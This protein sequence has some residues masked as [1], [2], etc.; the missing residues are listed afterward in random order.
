MKT[1]DPNHICPYTGLRSFTEEESLYFKGRDLQVDQITALLEQNKFLMVTGASGEG[2]SSLI[3]A[4]LI[5]NARAGFF[6]ARYSNWLV[7]DFR[8]ER[9][10]VANLAASIAAQLQLS[11]AIVET[12]L[13]RGYSSLVDLYLNSAFYAGEEEISLE[14]KRQSANLLILVDQFEE[15]FTNPENFFND[16][17][18]KDAQIV[19]NLLLETARISISRNLPVYV[20][21][22]MRSDYIGQCSSFRGLPEYIGF[23]QFF[24]PRLKR[25]DLKQVIEEPA[26]LSGNRITQRLIE[27]LVYDLADGVDQL[28]I[29][30]HALSRIWQAADNGRAEMDLL[31]YA[32]VGGMP[33]DDLP[34]ADLQQFNSWFLSIPAQQQKLYAETGLQKVIEIHASQLYENAADEYNHQYPEQP[35]SQKEAKRIIALT[36]SCLTKY[37]NSRA[38]R[39]RMSL[40]EITSII[41]SPNLTPE[42]IGRVIN[43]YREEG[44]SFIRPFKTDDPKTHDLSPGAV[45]DI[46]HESL[47][48]NWNKLNQWANREFEFYATYLDFQKQVERWKSSGKSSGYLLPIG[49]L[50][51]FENWYA[52]CK[53][54]AGWIRRYNAITEDP[55]AALQAAETD[56]QDTREFLKKSARKEMVTR[57]F[58]KYGPKKIAAI[59]A[60]FIMLVL[61][62]YYWYDAEQK[63]NESV[64]SKLRKES[65]ELMNSQ[66]V[67]IQEKA[68]YML[69]EERYQQ[70]SLIPALASRDYTSR[71]KI[72]VEAYKQMLSLDKHQEPPLNKSLRTLITKNLLHPEKEA[73]PEFLLLEGNKFVVELAMD[74]YYH[75]DAEKLAALDSVTYNNYLLVLRFLREK[76]LYR[77]T[78]PIEMNLA[79]QYWLSVGKPG[80]DQLKTLLLAISPNASPESAAAFNLYYP[81]GSYETN[82]RML[83][84][85][86]GG[87]HT[88]A[89]IYSALGDTENIIACF[90]QILANNQ[91]DY[92]ELPRLLNSHLNIIGFLYQ[93]GYRPQAQMIIQWIST[94][95]RDNTPQILLRNIAI[96]SGYITHMYVLNTLRTY[97]RSTRGYIFPNL[98]FCDRAVFDTIMVDYD[99]EMMKEPNPAERNFDLAMNA[100][101]KAIFYAKY[102]WDRNMPADEVRLD[103]YLKTAMEYY[104]KVPEDSLDAM[105]A[106]TIIYNGDG[107]RSKLVS[108][109]NLFIYPDYRDGWYAWTFHGDY[110]F[111]YLRKNGLLPVLFKTG[112]DLQELHYWIAKA[113]EIKPD[114]SPEAYSK[115]NTLADSTLL[116]VISFV[117]QHPEGNAFDKNL[118]YLVLANRAFERG[119]S[120][121]GLKYTEL[122][123]LRVIRSSKDRYEYVEK[124]FMMNQMREMAEHL[125]AIG[126]ME[127]SI[128]YVELFEEDHEKVLGYLHVAGKMYRQGADPRAF[129]YLDSAYANIAR[130]DYA[131]LPDALDPRTDQLLVL[132]E[133]G[134]KTINAHAKEVLRDIPEGAK[135]GAIYYQVIG[136]SYEGNYYRALTSLPTTLTESQDLICRTLILLE[137]CRAKERLSGDTSWKPFDEYLFWDINYINYLPN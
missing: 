105:T 6:K 56:L 24:V 91:R 5:P 112:K 104:A 48:R 57:A 68:L 93:Y 19:V 13:R 85:F 76:N 111:N 120:T 118:P 20:V 61:T 64:I 37:D 7:A 108:R 80:T 32:M 96:R 124:V 55:A 121:L 135:F 58:M 16:V 82:G 45:L 9:N 123:D 71:V 18:S 66:Q 41:N 38:V 81:K 60:I 125:A 11:A 103:A 15:F 28:P 122:V 35:V 14:K 46:T 67:N 73:D 27:R 99:K 31:H 87:Y 42:I 3:Y 65:A 25:K 114:I 40:A 106:T 115:A 50:T 30:Q 113:F 53:P 12:E 128:R 132:S 2:K 136:I 10:P 131:K 116:N 133:I 94:N 129:V 59:F 102:W 130:L 84:D 92:F 52:N 83:N 36:F 54:N 26:I 8:P 126:Q 98:Y 79:I 21:C 86:N 22:T 29:L 44:N 70:G 78:I 137:A 51:Y 63:K 89:S 88:L 34:D 23:S 74:Q 17:H 62:G 4:G 47:I 101:R 95:T 100:K 134:S 72:A 69:S 119:D 97:H 117:Q 49:P 33:A 127:K 109:R 77:P 75:P 1:T 43:I 39:N 107:V 90:R 110:Y